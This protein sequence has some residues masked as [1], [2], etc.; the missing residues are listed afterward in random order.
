MS[1]CNTRIEWIDVAKAI[2]IIAIVAGHFDI[3]YIDRIVYPWHVPF[4]FFVG[5]FFLSERESSLSFIKKK[6]KALLLPFVLTAGAIVLSLTVKSFILGGD[7]G[8]VFLRSLAAAFYGSGS[9]KGASTFGIGNIGAIWF[10][11]AM[12]WAMLLVRLTNIWVIGSLALISWISAQFVWFPLN[13]QSGALASV[14]VYLGRHA[15]QN[16][17]LLRSTNRP[18]FFL[19]FLSLLGVIFVNPTIFYVKNLCSI[20]S[21]VSSVFII[22]FIISLFRMISRVR[23]VNKIG[24]VIGM[25]TLAILCLHSFQLKVFSWNDLWAIMPLRGGGASALCPFFARVQ[26]CLSLHWDF[27]HQQG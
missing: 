12:F 17:T 13:L 9:M 18:L 23:R 10:L 25:N 19:G 3:S 20:L 1:T 16:T 2:A 27:I 8:E 5:G 4:F 22:Y 26:Y 14:Y 24:S 21:I 15:Y 6:A 7:G 11:E